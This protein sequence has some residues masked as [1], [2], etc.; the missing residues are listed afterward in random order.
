MLLPTRQVHVYFDWQ[1]NRTG[2]T[3]RHTLEFQ[4]K[5][6]VKSPSHFLGR[7]PPELPSEASQQAICGPGEIL[8]VERTQP[9][10]WYFCQYPFRAT[11]VKV[12][13][14]VA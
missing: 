11:L 4:G 13:L 1:S 10:R 5:S 3:I 7:C 2:V 9:P 14:A 8:Y 12:S 6:S